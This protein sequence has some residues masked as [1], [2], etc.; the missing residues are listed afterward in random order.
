M[1]D[2]GRTVRLLV[3]LPAA[4][5]HVGPVVRRGADAQL[6]PCRRPRLRGG[7][8]PVAGG[9]GVVE[10]GRRRTHRPVSGLEGGRSG[11][12]VVGR[13][14]HHDGGHHGRR[15]LPALPRAGQ[16][17]SIRSASSATRRRRWGST[18][19]T[20]SCASSKSASRPPHRRQRRR[21]RPP[22][23][24]G[25]LLATARAVW[26][27]NRRRS[28][29][30]S[31]PSSGSTCRCSTGPAT[32]TTSRSRSGS[33]RRSIGRYRTVVRGG[34]L[35]AE[36]A[37]AAIQADPNV[38]ADLRPGAVHQGARRITPGCA[39]ATATSSTIA[40]PWK[41]AVEVIDVTPAFVPSGHARGAHGVR[42]DRDAHSDDAA[43]T[44]SPT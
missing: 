30:S 15:R 11:P 16:R 37:M 31:G 28:P 40:G 8:R 35:G 5:G 25:G 21:R 13:P 14:R 2:G 36:E 26:S 12:P 32:S 23:V 9:H 19:S 34:A 38:L 39:S 42:R 6:R 1:A 44:A 24:Q 7:V 10:R 29:T 22:T 43:P 41:G 18:T 17:A 27:W 4:A 33:A 3:R 20:A